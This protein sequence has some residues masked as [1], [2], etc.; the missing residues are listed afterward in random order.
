M[1]YGSLRFMLFV[2]ARICLKHF[3]F[4]NY[5]TLASKIL[6]TVYNCYPL[7]CSIVEQPSRVWQF[8]S[9]LHQSVS[10]FLPRG[11][12]KADVSESTFDNYEKADVWRSEFD[13][14]KQEAEGCCT[15]P[16][17]QMTRSITQISC[18][19]C[20]GQGHEH[21]GQLRKKNM[22]KRTPG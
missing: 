13:E 2:L 19:W 9:S 20:E 6:F 8:P 7:S 16:P 15:P 18:E 14:W 3:L 17:T 1:G 12:E 11:Q 22:L 4:T 10:S 21:G 5:E